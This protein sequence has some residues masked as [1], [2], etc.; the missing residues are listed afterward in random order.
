MQRG[1]GNSSAAADRRG[2]SHHRTMEG[3]LQL[4]EGADAG[5]QEQGNE[6]GGGA[7]RTEAARCGRRRGAAPT[8]ANAE[9]KEQQLIG[10]GVGRERGVPN[11]PF[12]PIG[13]KSVS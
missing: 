10:F 11:R 7:G 3:G 8:A 9:D 6:R 12:P 1:K 13:K 4:E 2:A 5:E